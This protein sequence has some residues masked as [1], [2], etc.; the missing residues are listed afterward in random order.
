MNRGNSVDSNTT[1]KVLPVKF[2]FFFPIFEMGACFSTEG[3]DSEAR[4]RTAVIDR[5]IED[6]ARR[7]KKECKI[8][9]LGNV[10]WGGPSRNVLY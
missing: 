6:D 10:H 7:L 9:L 4:K 1:S 3:D 5:K 8:L 2:F